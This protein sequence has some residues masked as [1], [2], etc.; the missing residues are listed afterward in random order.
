M[1][2]V[3]LAYPNGSVAGPHVAR[4][5]RKVAEV[6]HVDLAPLPDEGVLRARLPLGRTARAAARKAN[7]KPDLF[8]Q[9]D[10]PGSKHL[11][12]P[13]ALG[14]P[15]AFWAV[16]SHRSEKREFLRYVALSFDHVFVAQKDDVAAFRAPATKSHWLPL[17]CDPDVHRDLGTPREVDVAHVGGSPAGGPR[18]GPIQLLA[19]T[20]KV[21]ARATA[22]PAEASALYSRS[23]VA[24]H[25]SLDGELDARVFEAM[26]CG[27]CL[28]TDRIRDLEGLFRD[29]EHLVL[30]DE[31]DML[32]V[33]DET[34]ADEEGRERIARAGQ[35]LVR[36]RHTYAHRVAELLRTLGYRQEADA[37][38]P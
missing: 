16:E 28:V 24:F 38:P 8:V 18:A 33:V 3:L 19:R 17:A 10:G 5:L 14:C 25:R 30:Y 1:I 9:V 23:K 13:R 6:R 22:S 12:D 11:R 31:W 2:R 37:V 36:E 20:Y 4:A 21:E 27:A 7:V 29:R 34:M 32:D 35:T 15:T 26:A